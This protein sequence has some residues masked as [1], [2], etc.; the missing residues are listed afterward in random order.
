M[1]AGESNSVENKLT[2]SRKHTQ[3]F[4]LEIKFLNK[5]FSL[6]WWNIYRFLFIKFTMHHVNSS[7]ET[8]MKYKIMKIKCYFRSYMLMHWLHKHWSLIAPLMPRTTNS[9]PGLW[10]HIN[11]RHLDSDFFH[12]LFLYVP[13]CTKLIFTCKYHLWISISCNQVFPLL[14]VRKIIRFILDISTTFVKKVKLY[15]CNM[16]VQSA[17]FS[18]AS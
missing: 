18:Y 15:S 10:C 12:Q 6:K 1:E 7:K 14:H 5:W 3:I 16:A 2:E 8:V 9:I 13:F 4:I 17:L 11:L